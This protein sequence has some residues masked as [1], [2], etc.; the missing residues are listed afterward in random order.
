M[1]R[2][3]RAPLEHEE[4]PTPFTMNVLTPIASAAAGTFRALKVWRNQ[5]L[6]T[7]QVPWQIQQLRMVT[8]LLQDVDRLERLR[9]VPAKQC[10]NFR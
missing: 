2:S 8:E 9:I 7:A 4:L 1:N 5:R 3:G 10:L 6:G